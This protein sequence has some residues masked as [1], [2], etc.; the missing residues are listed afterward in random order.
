ML[1]LRSEKDL[2]VLCHCIKTHWGPILKQSQQIKIIGVYLS[3][4]FTPLLSILV[5]LQDCESILSVRSDS[6]SDEHCWSSARTH[7]QDAVVSS[8]S[9]G[10]ALNLSGMKTWLH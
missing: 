7:S 1:Y 2:W 9:L 4:H 5:L 3:V 6:F 10:V 8:L